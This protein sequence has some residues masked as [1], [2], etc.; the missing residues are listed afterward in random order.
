MV[1]AVRQ[2]N[3]GSGVGSASEC[4]GC[5]P[6]DPRN[7]AQLTENRESRIALTKK[8]AFPAS[9]YC[10]GGMALP[11]PATDPPELEIIR[12]RSWR[13]DAA[14][15]RARGCRSDPRRRRPPPWSAASPEAACRSSR[16]SPSAVRSRAG[17]CGRHGEVAIRRRGPVGGPAAFNRLT[18]FRNSFRRGRRRVRAESSAHSTARHRSAPAHRR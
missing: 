5:S 11:R 9:S 14:R 7:S 15:T 10:R 8:W 3:R 1:E 17:C 12:A 2:D 6:A 16:S 18:H 13:A 4:S